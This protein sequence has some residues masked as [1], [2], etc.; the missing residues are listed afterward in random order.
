MGKGHSFPIYAAIF[1]FI[2]FTM[3]GG[4]NCHTRSDFIED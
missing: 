3:N 4:V 1:F 2:E